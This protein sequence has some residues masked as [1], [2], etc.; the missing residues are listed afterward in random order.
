MR[1]GGGGS[2]VLNHH[3]G[4]E[5]RVRVLP[6]LQSTSQGV[7]VASLKSRRSHVRTRG[8]GLVPAQR[9]RTPRALLFVETPLENTRVK[10]GTVKAMDAQDSHGTQTLCRTHSA[11]ASEMVPA[12]PPP[13]GSEVGRAE[14]TGFD[15]LGNVDGRRDEGWQ[16]A[17]ALFFGYNPCSIVEIVHFIPVISE[18]RT[19]VCSQTA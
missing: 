11:T 18:E 6:I 14:F 12:A 13:L 19:D 4:P 17:E 7:H 5:E 2:L 9:A 15:F 3:H 1:Q 8:R 16:R 10:P